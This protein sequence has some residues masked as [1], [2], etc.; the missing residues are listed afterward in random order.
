MKIIR[1][2]KEIQTNKIPGA[3]AG[4]GKEKKEC[5]KCWI[6]AQVMREWRIQ[7]SKVP[8]YCSRGRSANIE[9]SRSRWIMPMNQYSSKELWILKNHRNNSINQPQAISVKLRSVIHHPL[10][11]LKWQKETNWKTY[12]L[13]NKGNSC[14]SSI[15]LKSTSYNWRRTSCNP[16][17]STRALINQSIKCAISWNWDNF[18]WKKRDSWANQTPQTA[19]TTETTGWGTATLTKR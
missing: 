12:I 18:W 9:R 4:R 17:S 15:L 6:R 19:I 5:S 11:G 3:K 16:R 10:K 14:P 13:K 1:F 8:D 7:T 2:R